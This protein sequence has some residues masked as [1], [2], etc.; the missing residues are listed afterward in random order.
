MTQD[1]SFEKLEPAN[2]IVIGDGKNQSKAF[3]GLLLD[4]TPDE[5]YPDKLRYLCVGRDGEEYEIAGNAALSR[6]IKRSHIG[7]LI[8]LKFMG[9]ERVGN[10]TFKVI[11]VSAQPR[12]RTTD[13][14]KERFPRWHDF[15][16]AANGSD[17]VDDTVPADAAKEAKE[18]DDALDI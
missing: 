11:E 17:A 12:S 8:K 13:D 2:L 16:D 10:N 15:E 14:Q 1:D 4:I 7:C 3:G 6:R 9:K 18:A 5:K